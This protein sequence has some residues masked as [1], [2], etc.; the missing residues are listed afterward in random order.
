MEVGEVV[1]GGMGVMEEE[2]GGEEEEEEEEEEGEEGRGR[3]VQSGVGGVI[4]QNTATTS[5]R[6]A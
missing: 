3:E 6:S 4:K 1:D 5:E 2:E